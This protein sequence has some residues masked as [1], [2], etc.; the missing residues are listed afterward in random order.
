MDKSDI[1]IVIGREFGAG[2]RRIGQLVAKRL[3]FAYYD[4]ELLKEASRR[5]GFAPDLFAACDEK[6]P[7]PL[8]ALLQSAYGVA[9]NYSLSPVSKEGIYRAQSDVI[10]SIAEK[11]NC[12]IVGRTADYIMRHHPGLLSVFLCAPLEHRAKGIVSRGD[13]K[14]EE[15]AMAKAKKADSEREGYYNYYSGRKWGKASNYHLCLDTSK[16][17]DEKI[18]DIIVAAVR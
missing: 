10:R 15:E 6:R 12:V 9:E 13:A 3:G 17:S 14:S 11:E 16:L 1:V 18:A 4:K 7:S 8:S 5:L 2:G